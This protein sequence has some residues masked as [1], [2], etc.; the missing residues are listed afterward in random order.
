MQVREVLAGLLPTAADLLSGTLTLAEE[1][2]DQAAA[3][4]RGPF[5]SFDLEAAG[6]RAQLE[7]SFLSRGLAAELLGDD[8]DPDALSREPLLVQ[9][10]AL[11]F[12]DAA[13]ASAAMG[14]LQAAS[15]ATLVDPGAS[16]TP[17]GLSEVT[18]AVGDSAR[19]LGLS[20]P[21][22]SLAGDFPVWTEVVA[23]Q[24]GRILAGVVVF[25]VTPSEAVVADLSQLFDMRIREALALLPPGEPEPVDAE[26]EAA[27]RA[28]A[29]AEARWRDA[30]LSAYSFRFVR[31]CEFD[32]SFGGPFDVRVVD[33]RVLDFRR[34][35]VQADLAAA[36]TISELFVAIA[37]AIE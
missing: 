17:S 37:A 35:D 6:W 23:F 32:E 13:G 16:G 29:A 25:A 21:E 3:A 19:A 11:Y 34:A 28:L 27:R 5:V 7:R 33:E 24:R 36:T 9:F 18:L 2:Q 15:L 4:R 26:Q 12:D 14:I 30:G 8:I 10:S 31:Y 1:Y 20:S 22:G